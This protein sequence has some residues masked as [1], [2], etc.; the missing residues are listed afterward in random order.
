MNEKSSYEQWTRK[1]LCVFVIITYE[2]HNV[3]ET[4]THGRVEAVAGEE[5]SDKIL[6][7]RVELMAWT[8]IRLF[9]FL[10]FEYDDDCVSTNV[11]LSLRLTQYNFPSSANVKSLFPC[12]QSLDCLAVDSTRIGFCASSES[13]TKRYQLELSDSVVLVLSVHSLD[14]TPI[15]L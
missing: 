3:L 9:S 12:L 13:S 5:E 6:E 4:Y 15:R 7:S 10:L 8:W 1:T 14:P 2:C 11:I